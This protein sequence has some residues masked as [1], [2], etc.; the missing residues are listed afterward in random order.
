MGADFICYML[1]GPS[2]LSRSKALHKKAE[3]MLISYCDVATDAKKLTD[4]IDSGSI[5]G[6]ESAQQL[7]DALKLDL[8]KPHEEICDCLWAAAYQDNPVRL[9]DELFDVWDGSRDSA[10]RN[11]PRDPKRRFWTAGEMSWGDEPD[12]FGYQTMKHAD[13]VGLLALYGI[14]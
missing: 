10:Y 6:A 3:K 11:D 7:L 5:E 4:I 14:E 2:K 13:A 12:G 1:V 8:F 9:I